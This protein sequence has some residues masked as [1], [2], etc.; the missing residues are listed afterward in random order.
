[1]IRSY[2]S[3]KVSILLSLVGYGDISPETGLGK[4]I[5]L[6]TACSGVIV[7]SLPIPIIV[8]NFAMFYEI[9]RKKEKAK[10]RQIRLARLEEAEG[11]YSAKGV[12]RCDD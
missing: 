12:D 3:L 4:F 8:A 7:M 6:F 11:E 1:M 5:G 9:E 10:Q 2:S